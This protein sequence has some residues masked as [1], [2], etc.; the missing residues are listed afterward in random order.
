MSDDVIK[1]ILLKLHGV[2][3]CDATDDW[4]K[5]WDQAISVALC[6]VKKETGIGIEDVLE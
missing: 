3:G 2:G 5:G 4:A 1:N 6:I